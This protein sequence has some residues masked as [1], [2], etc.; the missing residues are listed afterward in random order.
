MRCFIFLLMLLMVRPAIASEQSRYLEPNRVLFEEPSEDE[1]LKINS[2]IGFTTVLEFPDK[3]SMV[4]TGDSSLLQIEVPKNSKNVLIKALRN[5]GET[6]LFVFT[7][8]QRFNYKVIV[9][10]KH[11]VDYVVDVKKDIKSKEKT[12]KKMPFTQL[13]KMAQNYRV[14]KD[15]KQINPRLFIQKD[16]FKEYNSPNLRLQ[17]VEVFKNIAPNYLVLHVV[18]HNMQNTTVEFNE[19]N[20]NIYINCQKFKPNF[21]LFDSTKLEERQKT[22]VWLV[23]ENTYVSLDNQ[24]SIGAGVYDKE[25]IF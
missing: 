2:A 8:N 11:E 10:D 21:V 22:D 17:V 13:I 4:S 24:F 3:P 23:L 19:K 25:Y 5:E 18:I 12:Q 15:S 6:N 16:I 1:V 9:G 7:P 14:L 20:T